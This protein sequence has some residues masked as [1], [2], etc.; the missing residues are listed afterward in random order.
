MLYVIGY[1]LFS[2]VIIGI[3]FYLIEHSP[4]GWEDESGFHVSSEPAPQLNNRVN[5]H[6]PNIEI[7]F[8]NTVA[9][10][11]SGN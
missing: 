9:R 5:Q 2:F 4:S 3:V 6:A 11:R 1:F 10:Y 8:G 7:I